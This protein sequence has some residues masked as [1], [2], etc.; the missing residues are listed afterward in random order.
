MD[1][2]QSASQAAR[3]PSGAAAAAAAAATTQYAHVACKI[4]QGEQ[5]LGL[6]FMVCLIKTSGTAAMLLVYVELSLNHRYM[7]L[8]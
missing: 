7:I 2:I 3:Q 4:S 1:N 5:F 6:V 8:G